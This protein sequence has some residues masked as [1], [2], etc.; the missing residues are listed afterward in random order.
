MFHSKGRG[1]NGL[2]GVA[3]SVRIPA[4]LLKRL[5]TYGNDKELTLAETLRT[6]LGLGLDA[7]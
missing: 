4:D 3:V 7:A 2:E 5:A 1:A 6:V